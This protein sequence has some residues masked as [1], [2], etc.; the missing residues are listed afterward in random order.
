L[1]D[2]YKYKCEKENIK[3]AVEKKEVKQE[4]Q[5]TPQ[6]SDDTFFFILKRQMK[7]A[8]ATGITMWGVNAISHGLPLLTN[9]LPMNISKPQKEQQSEPQT[10]FQPRCVDLEL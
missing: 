9:S 5:T 1:I 7:T 10:E 2:C 6:Q 8:I 3:P 4:V